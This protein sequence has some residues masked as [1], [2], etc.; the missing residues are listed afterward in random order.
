MGAATSTPAAWNKYETTTYT[1][2]CT[3]YFDVQSIDVD[4]HRI[5]GQPPHL[6]R[7]LNL[8]F[9]SQLEICVYCRFRFVM[10]KWSVQVSNWKFCIST[11]MRYRSGDFAFL[12]RRLFH[13]WNA[14]LLD[15]I[16]REHC[17]PLYKPTTTQN[18][19]TK[20]Q[21]NCNNN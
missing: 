6:G 16:Y 3:A 9:R 14:F 5:W 7:C 11:A 13:Y 17:T 1:C 2:R 8:N 21:I 20:S 10:G 19:V 12:L 18:V 15:L 4:P